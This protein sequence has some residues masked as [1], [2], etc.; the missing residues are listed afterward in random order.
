MSPL[1]TT[2]FRALNSGA[3]NGVFD[4]TFPTL[5]S[6]HQ[7]PWFMGALACLLALAL[8]RGNRHVRLWALAM[9]VAVG[10][11]DLLCS[12]VVKRVVVRERPCQAL[13]R[14]ALTPADVRVLVPERCPGSPSFPSN[15][16]SN[17]MAVGLVGWWF[18]RRRWR[19]AWL[20]LPLVIGYTRVYLGYHY[21]TDVL[22]GWALGAAVG[23]T[24][25]A[26]VQ[27]LAPQSTRRTDETAGSVG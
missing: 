6:L 10:C 7:L 3:A 18:A 23:A 26:V 17:T 21:P 19:W 5:T 14:G 15:H 27:R 2:V 1:D 8:W 4:A 25:L 13:A 16:A 20:A 11:S 12:K 24:V 9:V 22:C